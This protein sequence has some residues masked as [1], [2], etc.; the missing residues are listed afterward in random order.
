MRIKIKKNGGKFT[1]SLSQYELS[2]RYLELRLKNPPPRAGLEPATL[3]LTAG[4]STIELPRNLLLTP[5]L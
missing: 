4:C 5:P 3:R 1:K 2:I